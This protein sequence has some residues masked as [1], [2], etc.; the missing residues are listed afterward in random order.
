MMKQPLPRYVI[1]KLLKS[2]R[3]AFYFNVPNRYLK[4]GCPRLNDP[5]GDD[6]VEACGKNG[7][8]GRAA[9]LNGTVR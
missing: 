7:R 1:P 6:Y 8:G 4:A 2:G 9:T 3:I 5:L